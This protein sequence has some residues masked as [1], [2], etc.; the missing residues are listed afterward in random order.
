MSDERLSLP[1][2]SSRARDSRCH[3]ALNFI[4]A[5]RAS[6]VVLDDGNKPWTESGTRIHA[7]STGEEIDLEHDETLS[8]ET[9]QS[10]LARLREALGVPN[11]AEEIVERRFWLRD[12][13]KRIASGQPDR[14]WRF[15]RVSIIP[16][17]KTGWAQ[18]EPEDTNLQFRSYAV[19]EWLNGIDRQEVIVAT[20]NAHGAKPMPVKYD[21]AAL[22]QAEDEWRA[23]IAA[24]NQP[25]APRVAGPVQCKYC[26]AKIHCDKAQAIVPQVASLT[27]HE[28]GLTVTNEQIAELLDRCGLAKRM[29]GEIEAEAKRRLTEN[30]ESLPGWTLAPGRVAHPITALRTVLKRCIAHGIT[31]EAFTEKASMTKTNLTELLG[32]ALGIKGKAL[33]AIIDE[34][35]EGATADKPAAASLKRI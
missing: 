27:I 13:L 18:T 3:G 10:R 12:G 19:L 33:K 8:L 9:V 14:I 35:L 16:D 23:E 29:I 20:I 28:Q 2:A 34:V 15:D 21:V 30:P 4:R 25:D 5:L 31:A 22:M 6:G 26:P 1:S 7:A 17:I 24:C 32:D 11:D